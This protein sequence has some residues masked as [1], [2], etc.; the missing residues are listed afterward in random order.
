MGKESLM[1]LFAVVFI[2]DQ[3]KRLKTTS[4]GIKETPVMRGGKPLP[5]FHPSFRETKLKRL[6]GTS[7]TEETPVIRGGNP[8]RFGRSLLYY[9]LHASYTYPAKVLEIKY[10]AECNIGHTKEPLASHEVGNRF[11]F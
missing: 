1:H 7:D 11:F 5:H 10:T 2:R 3:A 8:L 4:S 6:K 9:V